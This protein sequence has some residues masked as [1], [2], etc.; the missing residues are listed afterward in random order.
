MRAAIL[1]VA[2]S[3]QAAVPGA[4]KL[5]MKGYPALGVPPIITVVKEG[6]APRVQLRYV[7][8]ADQ[9][10]RLDVTM[11]G[12]TSISV[13]IGGVVSKEALT[14]PTM[15]GTAD[16]AVTSIAPN[17]DIAYDVG[18]SAMTLEATAGVDPKVTRG[19]QA[20]ADRVSAVKGTAT[21]SSSGVTRAERID[22]PHP[23]MDAVLGGV[24]N[25]VEHLSIPFPDVAIGAGARWQVREAIEFRG[26]TNFRPTVFQQTEYEVLSIDGRTVSLQVKTEQTGPPQTLVNLTPPVANQG[27]AFGAENHLQKMSGSGTG[28]VVVHLDS[29]VPASERQSATSIAY[30]TSMNER[31]SAM[32]MDGKGKL[33][34]AAR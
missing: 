15:K 32:T 17:G 6:S 8:P 19:L 12:S 22:V 20:F 27:I 18:F 14:M 31:T 10:V 13:A 11:S 23:Q 24:I 9:K 7:I 4:Q 16:V 33:T 26:L 25:A 34:I 28:R 1:L 5:E 30:T 21:I 3:I 2:L 29:L